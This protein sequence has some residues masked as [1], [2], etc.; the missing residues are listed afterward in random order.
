[1][2]LDEAIRTRRSVRG[3]LPREVPQPLLDEVFELA[4]WSPSNCNIQ[5]WVPH[6]VSGPA[7]RHSTSVLPRATLAMI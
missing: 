2:S 1:M 4:Q 5:P 6:V 3:F 7:L